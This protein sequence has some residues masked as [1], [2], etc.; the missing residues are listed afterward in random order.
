MKDLTTQLSEFI[1]DAQDP[2]KRKALT[3]AEERLFRSMKTL[4]ERSVKGRE[5]NSTVFEAKIKER[6]G[7][8]FLMLMEGRHAM[9]VG[10]QVA[11]RF[12][13]TRGVDSVKV[14]KTKAGAC[15]I[16]RPE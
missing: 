11:R 10:S 5:V 2:P 14:V 12:D 6:S 3:V 16:L 9:S 13:G 1:A 7:V 8:S 15:V 4:G